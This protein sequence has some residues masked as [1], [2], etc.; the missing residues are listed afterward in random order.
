M[1]YF[2][3]ILGTLL[4]CALGVITALALEQ[5]DANRAQDDNA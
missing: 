5:R 3:W 4:A 1:W 2:A